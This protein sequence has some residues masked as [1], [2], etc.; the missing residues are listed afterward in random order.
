MSVHNCSDGLLRGSIG[1]VGGCIESIESI[2]SIDVYRAR[3]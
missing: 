2:E 3:M 1:P